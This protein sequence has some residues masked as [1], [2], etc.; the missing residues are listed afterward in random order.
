MDTFDAIQKLYWSV[1]DVYTAVRTDGNLPP[2][3]LC[4]K[5]ASDVEVM[6]DRLK[7]VLKQLKIASVYCKPYEIPEHLMDVDVKIKD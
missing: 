7:S 3:A 2:S 6:I 4:D 5:A 1:A